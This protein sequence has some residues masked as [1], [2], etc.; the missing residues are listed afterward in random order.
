MW[1]AS[2]L[3]RTATGMGL[4]VGFLAVSGCG[5]LLGQSI[6]DLNRGVAKREL[7]SFDVAVARLHDGW[8]YAELAVGGDATLD[9]VGEAIVRMIHDAA[10]T[11]EPVGLG[12]RD[13]EKEL[14]LKAATA[15]AVTRVRAVAAPPVTGFG[16]DN[17]RAQTQRVLDEYLELLCQW[18]GAG[19]P[20]SD[21]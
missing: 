15:M 1:R 12:E 19:T 17:I 16:V 13:P 11:A 2:V 18:T 20:S 8:R 6:A 21:R 4:A 5:P 9:V 3:R 14:A 7:V 10:K